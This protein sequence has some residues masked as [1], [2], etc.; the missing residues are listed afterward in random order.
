MM[1]PAPHRG[2]FMGRILLFG[3]FGCGSRGERGEELGHYVDLL[4]QIVGYRCRMKNEYERK[5]AMHDE[6]IEQIQVHV[7]DAKHV[8]VHLALSRKVQTL[9]L[10]HIPTPSRL[11]RIGQITRLDA[12]DPRHRQTLSVVTTG[13]RRRD[14]RC[15]A[16]LDAP[17]PRFVLLSS[18]NNISPLVS[19]A[20]R[21]G[22]HLVELCRCHIKQSGRRADLFVVPIERVRIIET[23]EREEE[24]GITD[25][26][27]QLDFL[28]SR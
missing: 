27:F 2:P 20:A 26:S 18:G 1:W 23:E 3:S 24:D 5:E 25:A 10:L 9:P 21:A 17:R 22:A 19:G 7:S 28:Q 12:S 4:C 6:K 13:Q 11:L 14:L 8:V 16:P 15:G